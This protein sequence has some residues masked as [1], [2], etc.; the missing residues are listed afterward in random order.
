[1]LLALEFHQIP[2][3][4]KASLTSLWFTMT[5]HATSSLHRQQINKNHIKAKPVITETPKLI[6][7]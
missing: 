7:P 1:M 5:T 2:D 3:F 6:V 4:L